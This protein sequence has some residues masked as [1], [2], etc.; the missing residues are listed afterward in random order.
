MFESARDER[1][2]KWTTSTTY[3]QFGQ[4]ATHGSDVLVDRERLDLD[5]TRNGWEGEGG[6]VSEALR[7]GES[8]EK[9]REP[10]PL[11][12]QGE[13][14]VQ[15][16][17]QD[18]LDRSAHLDL[19][20]LDAQGK[21]LE[22]QTKHLGQ[23][24]VLHLR[25]VSELGEEVECQPFLYSTCTS[26]TLS[27]VAL[28]DPGLDKLGDL[29]FLVESGSEGAE[30]FAVSLK[31][32]SELQPTGE[33]APHLTVFTGV[34]DAD[35]VRNGDSRL[36]DVG[37]DDDLAHPGRGSVEDGTLTLG[38]DTVSTTTNDGQRAAPM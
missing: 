23:R 26:T 18:L 29:P 21:V 22:R 32:T 19:E 9:I 35:T 36:S 37:R 8:A 10:T 4:K 1:T 30:I 16:L 20:D 2:G 3:W 13:G 14:R 17:G 24:V 28:G 11:D 34:N 25:L 15:R 6:E 5:Q 7:S 33:D 12:V 27:C 31:A 38:G